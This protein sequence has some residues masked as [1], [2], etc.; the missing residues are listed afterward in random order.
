MVPIQS[1]AWCLDNSSF[2]TYLIFFPLWVFTLGLFIT[3]CCKVV[4]GNN[5]SNHVSYDWHILNLT[6]HSLTNLSIGLLFLNLYNSPR[7]RILVPPC[8][9]AG[10]TEIF[11]KE[12]KEF[13]HG[14]KSYSFWALS[15]ITAT[16]LLPSS[17]NRRSP[18]F[19]AHSGHQFQGL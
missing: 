16:L 15:D 9:T 19:A 5:V 13:V 18:E 7:N 8:F 12:V 11:N 14:P 6:C 1:I 2:S 3:D 10:K 17:S 4:H